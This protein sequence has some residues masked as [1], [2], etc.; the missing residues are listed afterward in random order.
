[1]AVHSIRRLAMLNPRI[2]APGHGR[3]LAGAEVA[4]K[5]NRLSDEFIA[6]ELKG[7]RRH[8]A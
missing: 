6:E 7:G 1:M 2:L 4:E 5:L 3:A 8:V